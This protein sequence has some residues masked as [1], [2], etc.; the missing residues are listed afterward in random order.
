MLKTLYVVKHSTNAVLSFMKAREVL[1]KDNLIFK[2]FDIGTR[3]ADKR[4]VVRVVCAGRG[5]EGGGTQLPFSLCIPC[6]LSRLL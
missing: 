4:E 5:G 6:L 3:T 2:D 1:F